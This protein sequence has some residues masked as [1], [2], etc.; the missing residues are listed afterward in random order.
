SEPEKKKALEECLSQS[1]GR[2]MRAAVR[3]RQAASPPVGR[4]VIDRVYDAFG[5]AGVELVD[6][7]D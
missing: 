1:F 5:R 7:P 3:V 4:Q 2:P 6:Q